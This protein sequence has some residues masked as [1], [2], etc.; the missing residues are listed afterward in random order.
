[1]RDTTVRMI[2]ELIN[3]DCLVFWNEEA[4]SAAIRVKTY[5]SNSFEEPKG[6][7]M[8]KLDDRATMIFMSK[9]THITFEGC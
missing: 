7:L 8:L 1:M 9:I 2:I 5:L 4:K 6:Y 3:E